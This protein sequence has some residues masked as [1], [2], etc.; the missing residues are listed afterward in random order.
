MKQANPKETLQLLNDLAVRAGE[1]EETQE[2]AMLVML[3]ILNGIYEQ[4]TH[5]TH[6]VETQISLASAARD[7]PG[8]ESERGSGSSSRSPTET[9]FKKAI[10]L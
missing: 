5:L 7:L 3:E 10:R 6:T 9:L 4:L 2:A 1:G 8:E